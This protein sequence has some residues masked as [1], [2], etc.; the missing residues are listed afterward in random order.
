M[1]CIA[2]CAS[3]AVPDALHSRKTAFRQSGFFAY[4]GYIKIV[5]SYVTSFLLIFD[6]MQPPQ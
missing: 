3:R 1:R 4:S 2:L 5:D 6:K